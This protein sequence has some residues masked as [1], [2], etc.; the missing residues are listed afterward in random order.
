[1][2]PIEIR[3]ALIS[4]YQKAGALPSGCQWS[5]DTNLV[6][7]CPWLSQSEAAC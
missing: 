1:M 4:A 5:W 3:N 7:L 2:V 6:P